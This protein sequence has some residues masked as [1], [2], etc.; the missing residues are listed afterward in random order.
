M[1]RPRPAGGARAGPRRA[2]PPPSS[3]SRAHARGPRRLGVLAPLASSNILNTELPLSTLAGELSEEDTVQ[4]REDASARKWGYL[5]T[6]RAGK[7]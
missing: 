2:A 5:A 4:G 6:A 7:G 1:R 3:R